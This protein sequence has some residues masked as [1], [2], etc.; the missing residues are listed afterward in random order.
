MVNINTHK[1]IAA[2]LNACNVTDGEMQPNLFKQIHHKIHEIS[3]DRAY[4]TKQYYK[5]FG[6]N[7]LFLSS[8]EEE[9]QF[10]GNTIIRAI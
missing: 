8:H 2:K 9:V 3:G 5:P 6:L 1:V 10:L 7:E 4:D